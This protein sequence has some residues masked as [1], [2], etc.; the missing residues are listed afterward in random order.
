VQALY[1]VESESGNMSDDKAINLL[2][3]YLD[4]TSDLFLFLVYLITEVARYAET[5]AKNKASK[6]LPSVAD[7]SINTKIA[8]NTLLWSIF[9]LPGFKSGI[10]DTDLL[11]TKGT[12]SG[13]FELIS[14]TKEDIF[15]LSS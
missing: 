3:K 2:K 6:H 12:V 15:I 14:Y 11:H 4:E 8:G 13:V 1:A 9:E 10:K 5:H 7:L